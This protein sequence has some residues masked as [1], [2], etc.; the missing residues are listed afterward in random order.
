MARVVRCTCFGGDCLSADGLPTQGRCENSINN[1]NCEGS[2]GPARCPGGA[3]TPD[4][5]AEPATRAVEVASAAIAGCHATGQCQ[6]PKGPEQRGPGPGR[7]DPGAAIGCRSSESSR[8]GLLQR[9]R[10][11]YRSG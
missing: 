5:A 7:C 10:R 2:T 6:R 11:K 3:T 8:P 9:Y 1:R 4:R